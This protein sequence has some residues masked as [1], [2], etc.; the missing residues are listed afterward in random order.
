MLNA[1]DLKTVMKSHNT[2][3]EEIETFEKDSIALKSEID[4]LKN[5]LNT[6]LGKE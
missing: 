5:T 4:E 1:N 6:Q 3:I 2:F